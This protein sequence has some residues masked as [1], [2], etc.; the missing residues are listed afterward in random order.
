MAKGFTS[1]VR[2]VDISATVTLT[3]GGKILGCLA[4]IWS[5]PC[6]EW[7]WATCYFSFAQALLGDQCYAGGSSLI[8]FWRSDLPSYQEKAEQLDLLAWYR[9]WKWAEMLCYSQSLWETMQIIFCHSSNSLH[10]WKV[11]LFSPITQLCQ[12]GEFGSCVS[13]IPWTSPTTPYSSSLKPWCPAACVME[14]V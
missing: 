1:F 6:E 4:L 14:V 12:K 2:T 11:H 7:F 3:S 8:G 9:I 5:H 13:G 10:I